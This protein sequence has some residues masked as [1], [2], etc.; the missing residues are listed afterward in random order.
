[1]CFQAKMVNC[2]EGLEGTLKSFAFVILI[3][4]KRNIKPS[5]QKE[6]ISR[7]RGFCGPY[8]TLKTFYKKN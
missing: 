3:S 6:K 5:L 2:R 8:K 1:M 7:K 4:I